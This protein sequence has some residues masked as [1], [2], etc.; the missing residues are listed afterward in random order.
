[1][2]MTRRR[3]LAMLAG[4]AGAGLL[5]LHTAYSEPAPEALR[6]IAQRKGLRFGNAI[7]ATRFQD[8]A[9]RALMAREC[10]VMVAE[11]ETKWQAVQA[12]PGKFTFAP[13]DR[14]FSWARSQGMAVR[15][16]T[17]VWQP[18]KWLPRWVNEHDFGA[19]PVREAERLL[20][21]HIATVC[22]HFGKD[23]YSYD[24]VNEAIEPA[25]GGLRRNVFTER[26]G[27]VE[28]IDLAFRIAREHAP[29]AQLVYNDYMR[30]DAGSAKHRAGVLEL[31]RA[32]KARG[33]PV[34]A[35]GLQ[36]HIGSWDES[37]PAGADAMT[38]WR[39]FLD[40]A[41]GMGLDLLITEFD[42][43]DR[44]LPA[45]AA[46]RDA[47]VAALARDYLDVTLS[48]PRTRDLVLWGMADHASW[49]QSWDEAPRLDGLPMRPTPYSAQLQAKP[50]RAAIADALR[51][52]P[53]RA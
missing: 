30:W 42:V 38:E 20:R 52:M 22:R 31:L 17:L 21:E 24:V 28:Q 36:S 25:T 45:D 16:H 47:G 46:L 15:G 23:I 3:A 35:L 18:A 53:P 50:L 44:K 40:E 12:R 5:P 4:A 29:H 37:A 32:L 39:R 7:G 51:A 33:T 9:Y 11:N 2:T 48:Y 10:N 26:L 19:Q 13:A 41:T 49:L 6:A 1:M 34:H 8:P 43:N 14:M 27:A